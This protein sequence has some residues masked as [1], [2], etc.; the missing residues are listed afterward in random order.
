MSSQELLELTQQSET[1]LKQIRDL[2]SKERIEREAA[3]AAAPIVGL[4]RSFVKEGFT[5]EQSFELIK[6]VIS[7]GGKK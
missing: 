4:Y 7:M 3:E 6:T 5:E 2:K 1:I